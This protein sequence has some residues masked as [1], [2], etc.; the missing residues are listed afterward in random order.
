M[1]VPCLPCTA[2]YKYWKQRSGWTLPAFSWF[3]DQTIGG[4]IST[5]THGSTMKYGSLSA[6]VL[7]DT[8]QRW[9]GGV[10][11]VSCGVSACHSPSPRLAKACP[12]QAA[13][14]A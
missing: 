6:Q 14:R 1:P 9:T 13:T 3:L 2:E 7:G 8:C 5:A 12:Q 10:R 4:A 11:V